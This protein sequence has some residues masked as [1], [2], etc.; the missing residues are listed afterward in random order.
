MGPASSPLLPASIKARAVTLLEELCAISSATGEVEGLRRV[1]QRLSEELGRHGLSCEIREVA[2][3]EG[4]SNPVLVASA[5]HAGQHP[6]LLLGH[7]DTVLPAV[8]PVRDGDRLRGTGALDMKGGFAALVA[9]LEL[10]RERGQHAPADMLVVA[11]PDEEAEGRISEAAARHFSQGA[12]AVLVLEPGE[13][14][15]QGETLVAGRRGLTEWRLELMGRAAHSGLAFW[16]GRSALVAA[17]EWCV[18]AHRLSRPGRGATVNI[19]RLLAGTHDFV[20]RLPEGARLLGTSSQR[21]V[22]PDRAVV[23]GEARF[24]SPAEGS[25]ITARLAELA[26]RLSQRH[27]VTASLRVGTTVQPVDPGGAG[28]AL[29]RRTVELAAARGF[30]LEVEEDRGGVSF[31]NFLADPSRIP[32]VDGLGPV[33]EGMHTRGEY[34]DLGSLERRSVLLADLLTELAGATPARPPQ[35]QPRRRPREVRRGT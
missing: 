24:L 33:G 29:V 15:S 1:A 28:A 13:R 35:A 18:A 26:D 23:E 11:V 17:A 25:R 14:R 12:R 10:L 32:V 20:D 22:V 21:N 3:E 7:L 9:A 19:A 31:P 8:P 6:L 30:R 27:G 16:E 2:D 4:V 5:P 34:V